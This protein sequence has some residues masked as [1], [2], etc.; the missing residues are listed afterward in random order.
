[1]SP[2]ELRQ[3]VRILLGMG[4]RTAGDV[5]ASRHPCRIGGVWRCEVRHA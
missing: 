4:Y 1:M 2:A 5:L 3:A